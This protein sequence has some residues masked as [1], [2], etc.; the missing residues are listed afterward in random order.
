MLV[1][2]VWP[3]AGIGFALMVICS[4]FRVLLLLVCIPE[5]SS[6]MMAV[7]AVAVG[8]RVD[9]I[10]IG[11]VLIVPCLILC[12]N[13]RQA[14]GFWNK[15]FIG[16]AGVIC[17]MVCWLECISIPFVREFHARPNG[18]LFDY[19]SYPREIFT[20]LW[21]SHPI[22]C[23][24]SPLI[25]ILVGWLVSWLL[26]KS[27]NV[28]IVPA[29][30]VR[31]IATIAWGGVLVFCIRG[32]GRIPLNTAIASYSNNATAN[33]IA[34]NA[35]YSVLYSGYRRFQ[36]PD[37]AQLYGTMTDEEVMT[38]VANASGIR[39]QR[40]SG[41]QQAM[42]EHD[43]RQAVHPDKRRNLV[44]ILEESLGARFVGCLGGAS[45]TPNLD[46]WSQRGLLFSQ[47]FATGTRTYRG[48]EGVFAG[49]PPLPRQSILKINRYQQGC[50]TIASFLKPYGYATS[51]IYGGESHFDNM[52]AFL[53][54]NGV[55]TILDRADMPADGF[56]GTWGFC[57]EVVFNKAQEHFSLQQQP[58][59]S[60]ILTTSAHAPFEYPDNASAGQHAFA[61]TA[62][63]AVRYADRAIGAFL[64]RAQWSSWYANTVFVIVA[65]HDMYTS[66]NGAVPVSGFRIFALM[67]GPDIPARVYTSVASQIDLVPTAL[68]YLGI[69]GPSPFIGRDC[70][71]IPHVGHNRAVMQHYN[72][73]VYLADDRAVVLE[74]HRAASPYAYHG[75]ALEPQRHFDPEDVRNAL[76]HALVPRLLRPSRA[77]QSTTDRATP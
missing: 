55:D 13:R 52:R 9:L 68:P 63:G 73:F 11:Y 45:L 19:V 76:A 4:G 38:R 54:G 33:A 36:E 17:A 7:Q 6:P 29:W 30:P 27:I 16:Y 75:D 51:F 3:I 26:R 1:D 49:F 60:L 72:E 53:I 46:Q 35:L 20:T 25:A 28:R 14:L 22:V 69:S 58:F 74:P 42:F 67:I 32:A 48:V 5:V 41:E 34:M 23:M 66:G 37:P 8:F 65:D 40:N 57:D 15:A 44:I 39:L 47:L 62:E 24:Y 21:R 2:V 56:C 61:G 77:Y 18:L 64:D 59:C 71:E 10:A 50:A 70:L 12:I 31:I 43:I